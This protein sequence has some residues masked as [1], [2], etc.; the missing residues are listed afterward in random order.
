MRNFLTYICNRGGLIKPSDIVQISCVHAWSLYSYVSK[1]ANLSQH[2][3]ASPN[4]RDVFVH[5]YMK[6]IERSECTEYLFNAE[7]KSGCRF[8][9]QLK[10]IAAK[11]FDIKAKN[12]ASAAN[13]KQRE[14]TGPQVVW[15]DI[16]PHIT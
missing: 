6:E 15:R 14:E 13:D 2:L 11:T 4:P 12:F 3:Q 7:C 8:K 10:V 5:V 1:N 16:G 9:D